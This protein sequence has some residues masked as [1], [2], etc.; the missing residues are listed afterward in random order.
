MEILA[1]IP[2]RSGSK[3]L[4][5]KNIRPLSGHPLLAYSIEAALQTPEVSRVICSTDSED[6]ANI[7]KKYGAEVPF[8]RP[9]EYATDRATDLE[10]FTD[11]LR[12]LKETESYCPELV[13]N[14]RPTSPIRRLIDISTAVKTLLEDPYCDSVRSI[15]E[16][17]HTP[18][19]MWRLRAD[20]VLD[21]LLKLEGVQEPFN[22]NRQELP[23]IWAQTGTI[24]IVRAAVILGNKS[25]SGTRI[26]PVILDQTYYI[27]IDTE[28]SF[29]LAEM[30]LQ[31]MDCVRF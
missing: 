23:K 3:G 19:K 8:L 10:V 31:T 15:A 24:D 21:P 28:A 1:V 11:L 18:Y 9:E 13:L 30:A 29:K 27:D 22:S 14:L 17:D 26:K 7:A 16:V 4:P 5:N 2:A 6:Y 20:G 12:T 25:M